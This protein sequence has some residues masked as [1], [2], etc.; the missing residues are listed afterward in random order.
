LLPLESVNKVPEGIVNLA[1]IESP[2]TSLDTTK[3]TDAAIAPL[4]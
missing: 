4:A 3:S 2:D 1:P